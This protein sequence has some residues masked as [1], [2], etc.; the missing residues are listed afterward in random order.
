[1]IPFFKK[2]NFLSAKKKRDFAKFCEIAKIIESGEHLKKNGK[3]RIIEIRREMND[4]GN[5]KYSEEDI[6][7]KI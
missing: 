4:G 7:G 6:L 2:Y 3:R 1:M 5:R